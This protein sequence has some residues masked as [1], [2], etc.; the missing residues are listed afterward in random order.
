MPRPVPPDCPASPPIVR[1]G[2]TSIST[3]TLLVGGEIPLA[4]P[5]GNPWGDIFPALGAVPPVALPRAAAA[6]LGFKVPVVALLAPEPSLNQ[7]RPRP[8]RKRSSTPGPPPASVAA[9][10]ASCSPSPGV[11]WPTPL[12]NNTRDR[13]SSC[14][15]TGVEVSVIVGAEAKPP[16]LTCAVMSA[17]LASATM[18]RTGSSL[19]LPSKMI[20]PRVKV[21]VLPRRSTLPRICSS[22]PFMAG[23]ALVPVI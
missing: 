10:A 16:M 11:I 12:P 8:P 21:N 2:R 4:E 20:L 15:T 1:C 6:A 22:D 5:D 18:S 23:A 19:S 7:S 3:V 17:V 13:T 9:A 14:G